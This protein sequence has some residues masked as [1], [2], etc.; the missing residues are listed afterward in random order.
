MGTLSAAVCER[1]QRLHYPYSCELHAFETDAALIPLL[2]E[3]LLH[4]RAE[5]TRHGHTLDVTITRTILSWLRALQGVK[6]PC[7]TRTLLRP[8]STR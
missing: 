7:L 3:N 6:R 4:C 5:L 2:R 1:I 8:D